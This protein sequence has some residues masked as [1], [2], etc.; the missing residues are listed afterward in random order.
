M[1]G[2]I[3]INVF[4]FPI[5]SAS[6]YFSNKYFPN[7]T[8][9]FFSQVNLY[10]YTITRLLLLTTHFPHISSLTIP[11]ETWICAPASILAH[12]SI[13]LPYLPNLCAVLRPA[14][15][16]SYSFPLHSSPFLSPC[17]GLSLGQVCSAFKAGA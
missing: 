10:I 13:L 3:L 15:L 16:A 4:E 17:I 2:Q 7:Q 5:F 12:G 9:S 11:S 1:R 14:P 6:W 8:F